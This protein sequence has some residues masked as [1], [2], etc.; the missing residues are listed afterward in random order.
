MA[1]GVVSQRNWARSEEEMAAAPLPELT[2]AGP[3]V[4]GTP[5]RLYYLLAAKSVS[6]RLVI[7][8]ADGL[9][10]ELFCKRGV[11]EQART[12]LPALGLLP[13]LAGRGIL[14]AAAAAR[15]EAALPQAGGDPVGALIMQG[16]IP[17]ADLFGHL[18][19]HGQAVLQ[20]LL[21]CEHGRFTWDPEAAVPAG[22]FP[23]GEKWALLC[24]AGRSLG[25]DA[26]ARRLGDRI[27]CPVMR[28]GDGLVPIERL[29][30]TA[31][32]AR[33]LS[34][35]DGTRS[36]AQLA[37]EQQGEAAVIYRTGL[38][39]A[40]IGFASFARAVLP[41]PTGAPLPGGGRAEAP[42]PPPPKQQRAAPPKQHAHVQ[43]GAAR[44]FASPPGRYPTDEPGLRAFLGE[45]EGKNHF[46]VL[47]LPRAATPN[48]IKQAFFQRARAFHPDLAGAGGPEVRQLREAITARL[49]EAWSC[50]SDDARRHAYLGELEAG[51]AGKAIDVANLLVAEQLFHQATVMVKAR[52]FAEALAELDRA[53]ALNPDEGEFYAW[54]GYA[55]FSASLDKRLARDE[56][57][58]EIEHALALNG[59]CAPAFLFAARIATVLGDADD[60]IKYYRRCLA[61]DETNL[62]AQRELRLLESRISK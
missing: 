58:A 25:D 37:F 21:H 41:R 51:G 29:G 22:T 33:A 39:L 62:E 17:P 12:T 54:R 53:V 6:G 4:A 24:A 7:E 14:D 28:A 59:R 47:G 19:G 20:R 30:L 52:R 56:A 27:D 61:V 26:V 40:E 49:N 46:E 34:R 43:Q 3:V 10:H 44:S 60:A 8:E 57:M 42:A 31:H 13:W 2:V 18:G 15:A 36:L 11:P 23:L 5:L 35:F 55:R 50:L 38:F 9:R 32:E 45:L 48:L 1:E 16:L